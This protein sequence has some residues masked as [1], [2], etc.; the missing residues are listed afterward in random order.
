MKRSLFYIVILLFIRLV[1]NA[2]VRI[3]IIAY[4]KLLIP[5]NPIYLSTDFNNWNSGDPNYTFKKD[6]A[7]IYYIELENAP[8]N[9]EYK[10]TQGNWTMVEGDSAGNS[11]TN[12]VYHYNQE[13]NKHLIRTKIMGW[14]KRAMY[15]IY[16]SN[17]PKTTPHDAK[18]YLMGN[19]NNWEP[20]DP[21]Y[22]LKKNIDGNYHTMI[23]SDLTR[24]EFKVNR[25]TLES[26]ECRADGK[27]RPNRIILRNS[28]INHKLIPIEIE[29]WEDLSG[30]F[31]LIS[32]LDMLLLF[33][34]FQG[35]LL[36]IAIPTIHNYN[37][38]ANRWL[39]ISIGFASLMLLL[40]LISGYRQISLYYPKIN[41]VEDFA[42]FL[43]AP[44]FYFYLRKLLFDTQA[45]S[46][47][48][49]WH[50]VPAIIQ[51]FVY[52]PFF[53][54]DSNDFRLNYLNQTQT[55]QIL[56]IVSGIFSFI[57]N[58]YYWILFRKSINFYRKAYQTHYSYEQNL[59]YL[60]TVLV[61][62]AICLAIWFFMLLMASLNMFLHIDNSTIVARSIEGIWLIFSTITYFVGY[63]AIHQPE[64]FKVSPK[65]FSIFDDV[66]EH[67][68]V[69]TL[70]EV[71]QITIEEPDEN[72]QALK[73]KIEKYIQKNRPYTNPKLTLNELSNK[74][75]MPP[76][77]VSK[78]IND[79]F[80]KNFFDFINTYRIEEFKR[81]LQDPQF[82]HLTFLSLAYEVGFNSKT[83]FNRS[84]KKITDQTPKEYFDSIKQPV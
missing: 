33:S 57:W 21:M 49:F 2:Q 45:L 51:F 8:K 61:I 79:G 5:E 29:G 58:T 63:F 37:K 66:L 62:Q 13:T 4:P 26:V 59:Q 1:S 35:V 19:F 78:V 50:F 71:N 10:F 67:R 40:H 53:L 70:G 69:E 39:V 81:L 32:M 25:G 38:V 74:L 65:N 64:T 55:L 42:Y 72:M 76:H 36:I 27:D 47:R 52:L 82:Q 31:N 48:T 11:I 60:N 41:L 84:F 44:L 30:A 22:E 15:S 18:L 56:Y 17:I 46:T 7:G 75:K 80:D 83:A 77:L 12:R 28:S 34:V 14:E 43:Y 23:Y 3:E 54:M 9:F 73:G 16:T 24:L 20:A 68:V 6:P